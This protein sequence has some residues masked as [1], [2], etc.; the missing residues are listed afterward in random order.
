M[1][2]IDTVPRERALP[3]RELLRGAVPLAAL[4]ALPTARAQAQAAATDAKWFPGFEAA[5]VKPSDGA[6]IHTVK[7]GNGPPILLL[8]GA[9]QS[10]VSWH[11]VAQDLARDHTVV[12]ADLRG[13]GDSSKVQGSASHV[14]Y[15]KR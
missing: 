6:V 9:P 12:A 1:T 15:A 10:H 7:R 13:Y 4:A 5:D 14:E 2:T 3:R 8:H 11:A